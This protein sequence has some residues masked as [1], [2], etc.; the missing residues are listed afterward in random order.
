[1]TLDH[2]RE[3]NLHFRDHFMHTTQCLSRTHELLVASS[4]ISAFSLEPLLEFRR[5][6]YHLI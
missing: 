6:V 4:Q 3:T 5:K 2:C 1:M